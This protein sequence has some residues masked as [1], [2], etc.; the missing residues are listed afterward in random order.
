MGRDRFTRAVSDPDGIVEW[1]D[2]D[3]APFMQSEGFQYI[4][5]EVYEAKTKRP[6]WKDRPPA[7]GPQG[8]P[9]GEQFDFDDEDEVRRRLPR[10]AAKFPQG[11]G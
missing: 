3:D 8:E 9:A 5:S 7:V 11:G 6:L 4:A 1:V 2:A 10:L